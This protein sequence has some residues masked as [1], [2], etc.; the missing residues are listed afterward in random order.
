MQQPR[1][2]ER[3]E[4]QHGPAQP[5]SCRAAGA[6]PVD[7]REIGDRRGPDEREHADE[8]HGE[9]ERPVADA[10]RD[11]LAGHGAPAQPGE[12]GQADRRVKAW[13]EPPGVSTVPVPVPK[14]GST[15]PSGS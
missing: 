2:N 9:A 5:R 6:Q 8:W 11:Q 3:V 4:G 1:E 14:L 12:P 15:L 13:A 7:Q 10:D